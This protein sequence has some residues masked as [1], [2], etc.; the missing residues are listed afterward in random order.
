MS[1]VPP[2]TGLGRQCRELD[3][4]LVIADLSEDGPAFHDD[5]ATW[6]TGHRQR[7]TFGEPFVEGAHLLVDATLH[8]GCRYYGRTGG[9]ADSGAK[10]R[11]HGFAGPAPTA[12]APA[13]ADPKLGGDRFEAID[14][15]HRT[16]VTLP[17]KP[18][19][20]RSL[21]TL[22]FANPC[23]GAPCR[24]SDGA[25]G[26]ACCR[27]LVLDVAMPDVGSLDEA[28]LRN[29]ER[30]FISKVHRSS[31]TIMEAEVISACGYL[32]GD[33]VSCALHS[34]V[35]PDGRTAKPKICFDW[36]AEGPDYAYHPGCRLIPTRKR[37]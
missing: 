16:V 2:C 12:T 32:E 25:R 29:R 14:G 22:Q 31:D 21:P 19:P 30:P 36:P 5:M 23:A 28:L 4:T 27:D 11:A 35:R 3:V 24:T 18:A 37:S 33:S 15:L 7:L 1:R 20:K 13:V 9:Q 17:P 8:V 6:L 26:G 10:C 34:R